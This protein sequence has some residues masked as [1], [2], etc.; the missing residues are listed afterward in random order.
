M[1]DRQKQ[2]LLLIEKATGKAA[3][4]GV[5]KEEGEEAEYHDDTTDAAEDREAA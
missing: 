2:L 5:D 1:A 4:T 3:Y